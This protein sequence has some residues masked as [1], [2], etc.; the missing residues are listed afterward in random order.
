MHLVYVDESGDVGLTNSP[1]REY[2]LVAIIVPDKSWHKILAR[3]NRTRR[4]MKEKLG[5]DFA[6]EIHA[7]EF[8]GGA[9]THL[10]L[11]AWQRVR[12][13]RWLLKE[14]SREPELGFIAIGKTKLSGAEILHPSWSRLIEEA[15]NR[16]SERIMLLTDV[17]DRKA[18]L[19]AVHLREEE[20]GPNTQGPS[21]RLIEDPIHIDSRHSRFIQISD[22]IAYLLRQSLKPNAH[23]RNEQPRQLVR[24]ATKLTGGIIW[25]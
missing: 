3:I 4:R 15:E 8:L 9:H 16:T 14:L 24:M 1:T 2:L 23:F 13:I 25:A 6:A 11:E 21:E 19:K 7:A 10:G 18:V 17:T 20:D 5:L 12:A 22:L